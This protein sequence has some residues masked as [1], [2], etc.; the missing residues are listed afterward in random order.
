MWLTFK[1]FGGGYGLSQP[2]FD[3]RFYWLVDTHNKER[4]GK[5]GRFYHWIGGFGAQIDSYEWR[6]PNPGT[7]RRLV[8]RDFRVFSVS[9]QWPM[10][11]V[12]WAMTGMGKSLDQDNAQIA[13][14]K[15]ALHGF[16]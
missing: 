13:D 1:L 5:H 3:G 8:N 15:E 7:T 11:R 9:P 14:L 4:A 2:Y 6:I 12:S 10:V 16:L